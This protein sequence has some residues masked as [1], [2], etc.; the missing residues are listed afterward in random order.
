THEIERQLQAQGIPAHVVANSE[1]FALDPQ[2]CRD[3]HL[4]ELAHAHGGV[5]IVEGSRFRLSASA[6][7][8]RRAA[9]VYGRDNEAVLR[10][11]LG[12]S[13]AAIAAL[14][15]AKALR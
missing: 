12:Y 8:P 5:S 3:G 11:L 9:P 1:D 2:L 15:D 14:V 13:D 10:D 4:V 7:G 6:V